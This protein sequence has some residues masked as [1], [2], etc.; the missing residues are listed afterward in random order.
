MTTWS[1]LGHYGKKVHEVAELLL[2]HNMYHL[3][4]TDAHSSRNRRPKMEKAIKA[5]EGIIG[6]ENTAILLNNAQ[7]VVNNEDVKLLKPRIVDKSKGLMALIKK[8]L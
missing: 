7:S 6:V 1:I 8:I 4:A 2:E 3:L 5:V